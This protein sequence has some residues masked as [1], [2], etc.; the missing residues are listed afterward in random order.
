MPVIDIEDTK[1]LHLSQVLNFIRL[2]VVE[3]E[4]KD[5]VKQTV[6]RKKVFAAI[7]LFFS[8]LDYRVKLVSETYPMVIS[9]TYLERNNIWKYLWCR[10]TRG[11]A[12]AIYDDHVACVKMLLQRGVEITDKFIS[13][14]ADASSRRS[15]E[16][17]DT[18]QQEVA[19]KLYSDEDF[20]AYISAKRDGC[21]IGVNIY[22]KGTDLANLMERVADEQKMRFHTRIITMCKEN[23]DFPYVIVLSSNRCLFMQNDIKTYVMGATETQNIRQL[24]RYLMDT[25]QTF[26]E[27]EPI[28]ACLCFEALWSQT[29]QKGLTVKYTNSSFVFLGCTVFQDDVDYQFHPHFTYEPGQ[30]PWPQPLSKMIHSTSE[31]RQIISDLDKV[32]LGDMTQTDYL[33]QN[34]SDVKG[35]DIETKR[36]IDYEGLVIY[37]PH[38][39]EGVTYYDYSKIKTPLYYMLH[40]VK[41]KD[42]QK[43]VNMPSNLA[44]AYHFADIADF[45]ERFQTF[46]AYYV[47]EFHVRLNDE[48]KNNRNSPFY[49]EC[50]DS[51]GDGILER[52]EE[53]IKKIYVNQCPNAV[54]EVSK[55]IIRDYR[56]YR[57]VKRKEQSNSNDE[58]W[59]FAR[60]VLM[61]IQPLGNLTVSQCI[62]EENK[63]VQ[64]VYEKL[65]WYIL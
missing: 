43:L 55:Q 24:T 11:S 58:E 26:T 61:T 31:I 2:K 16:R 62:E 52:P 36:D 21:L 20:E 28:R 54:S 6:V 37:Y 49:L 9:I 4:Q 7:K 42:I 1:H 27:G 39:I 50:K 63:V 46:V 40:K 53:I 60:K 29:V 56:D 35:V 30:V 3:Q 8:S 12:F 45:K 23:E 65:R 64:L 15:V 34:W 5:D 17:L 48:I 33:I 57:H 13:H 59:L 41:P 38:Q 51:T 32:A 14:T 10:E 18:I 19:R 47:E 44:N 25:I 22:K